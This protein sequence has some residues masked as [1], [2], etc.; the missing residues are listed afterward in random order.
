MRKTT[1]SSWHIRFECLATLESGEC[2]QPL[3]DGE[4]NCTASAGYTAIHTYRTS[5][6][7][8]LICYACLAA[9]HS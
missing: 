1:P 3:C 7:Q 6:A 4:L 8:G 2:G 5:F 9:A